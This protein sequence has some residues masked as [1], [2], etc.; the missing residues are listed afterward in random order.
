MVF[1]M[2]WVERLGVSMMRRMPVESVSA[3]GARLGERRVLQD[4]R[5]GE[6][7]VGRFYANVERLCGDATREQQHDRLVAFGR[8]TGRVYVEYTVLSKIDRQ[9]LVE[10]EGLGN[11]EGRTRPTIFIAPHL[12]NWEL[13]AKVLAGLDNPTCALYEPR[14]S[15]FRMQ[16]AHQA[17]S[18]WGENIRLVSTASAMPMR[19]LETELRSGHNIFVLPDEEKGGF[20][21]APSLGRDLP[22]VGNRWMLSR[23]AVK[24]G[25]D[26]IPMVVE[27]LETVRS[28]VRVLPRLQ[29]Q[30]DGDPQERARFL[31]DAMDQQLDVLVRQRLQHWYWLPYLDLGKR[32]PRQASYR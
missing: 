17:R 32:H 1:W 26:I 5:A 14:E 7:W 21:S 30:P 4:A 10:V 31:A 8:Q 22:Y 25:I 19:T 16:I 18:A 9:G 29:A 20:V 24:H 15:G 13:T 6:E 11:L 23:L 27:R 28:R 12:A 2:G 3:L